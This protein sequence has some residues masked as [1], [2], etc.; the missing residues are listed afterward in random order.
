MSENTFSLD[1][2]Q[3]ILVSRE[4]FFPRQET[5]D[6]SQQGGFLP[7]FKLDANKNPGLM[8]VYQNGR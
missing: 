2:R 4:V 8:S 5:T 3:Q 7:L 6:T 1:R